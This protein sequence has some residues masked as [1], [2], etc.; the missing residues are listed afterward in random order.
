MSISRI[1]KA[2]NYIDDDLVS[3]CVNRESKNKWKKTWAIILVA[4]AISLLLMGAGITVSNYIVNTCSDEENGYELSGIELKNETVYLE[5]VPTSTD[6][7][8]TEDSILTNTMQI[9]VSADSIT[10]DTKI[11]LFL[12]NADNLDTPILYATITKNDKSVDFTNLTSRFAYKVGATV[13]GTDENVTL[14]I[15]D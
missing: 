10:G 8:L 5:V 12:Y 6:I 13:E 7:Q 4:A 11:S 15:T 14:K 3:G 1:A 2:L 9:T